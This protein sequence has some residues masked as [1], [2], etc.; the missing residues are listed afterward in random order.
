[1]SFYEFFY[2]AIFYI[3]IAI[4]AIVAIHYVY[5][6][7]NRNYWKNRGI[8]SPD[9]SLIFGDLPGQVKGNRNIMYDFDDLYKKYKK[10][11]AAI[12]I[13]NF[14]SPRLLVFNTDVIR[15]I[16]VKNFKNFPATEFYGKIDG[17]SDPLF[18]NHMFNQI[19]EGWKTSRQ[20][21]SP[22]FTNTRIKAAHP[23]MEN[24]VN[25]MKIYIKNEIAKKD[26]DGLDAKDLSARYTI[27]VVSNSIYNIDPKTF[28]GG[29]SELLKVA[30]KFL[31]PSKKFMFIFMLNSL[32]P[33]LLKHYKF[34]FSQPGS[35]KF[36]FDL[37][38]NSIKHREASGV[39]CMD[40]LDHLLTLKQKRE[41]SDQ[42][43]A[44][45]GASFLVDGYDTSSTTIAGS[46]L[47]IARYKNVQDKLREEINEKMPNDE[48]FNYDN[49]QE[50]EY[51]D[52]ILY[53]SLRMHNPALYLARMCTEDI[54]LELP[55]DKKVKMVKGDLAY[56]PVQ[57]IFMDSDYFENPTQF[58]P[59]R[60]SA[61]NGGVKAY[62]DRGVF[63]PFGAGPRMCP[64]N[65]F[66]FAQAKY[67]VASLVKDFE[68]SLNPR[69]N[70]NFEVHPNAFILHIQDCYINFKEIKN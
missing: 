11:H 21:L 18:G 2:S 53:E 44:S 66:A 40:Y 68:L 7:S 33:F 12:G 57:S 1:M 69:S 19:G 41:I 37:M 61:E 60:F 3:L 47:E 8:F 42:A 17:E 56:I 43:L 65:R 28:E 6:L 27:S 31:A 24:V 16:M 63:F 36:F 51:L 25:K 59:D 22:A 23:I 64:G 35:Q 67:A 58:N 39:K 48:D 38:D 32:Y 46:L 45:H 49:V 29:E 52:Q 15:D 5:F 13:F 4:I 9:S 14:R 70:P 54:E 10:S 55:K 26:F 20:E 34:S 30:Q 62:M 50:L